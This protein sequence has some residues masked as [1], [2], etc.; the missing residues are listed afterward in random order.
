MLAARGTHSGGWREECVLCSC[1]S[2]PP[3]GGEEGL[4]LRLLGEST[5]RLYVS[6]QAS[7]DSENNAFGNW[8]CMGFTSHTWASC[9][10]GKL[11][12]A[13]GNPGETPV[14]TR[15]EVGEELRRPSDMGVSLGKPLGPVS[16]R[17]GDAP[18]LLGVGRDRDSDGL[19]KL[20]GVNKIMSL[21][22]NLGVTRI[23]SKLEYIFFLKIYALLC[24]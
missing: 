8:A 7:R 22:Q 4:F 24:L 3:R 15:W 9:Q 12:W 10:V 18:Y 2:F 17:R 11:A 16:Q 23:R 13:A 19:E 14:L 20:V 21:S 1:H 5:C 6:M